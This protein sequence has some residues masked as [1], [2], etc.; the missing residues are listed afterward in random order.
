MIAR[1]L[2]AVRHAALCR[3]A[4]RR[5]RRAWHRGDD[6]TGWP[7]RHCKAAEL[8]DALAADINDTRTEVTR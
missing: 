6:L 2:A 4:S 1:L 5:E 3:R 8:R 7:L